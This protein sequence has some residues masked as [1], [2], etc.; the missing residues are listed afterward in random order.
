MVCK[1]SN[2]WFQASHLTTC[3]TQ[4]ILL[5]FA[6]AIF[7]RAVWMTNVSVSANPMLPRVFQL[8]TLSSSTC[9]QT[10]QTMFL[11][12]S[13]FPYLCVFIFYSNVKR[14][15]HYNT[16]Q[17]T[18]SY[19]AGFFYFNA[20]YHADTGFHCLIFCFY[21]S[22]VNSASLFIHYG[23]F[24]KTITVKSAHRTLKHTHSNLKWTYICELKS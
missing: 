18:S 10:L 8:N 2:V 20:S 15:S 21:Q 22:R 1:Y 7:T 13:I 6:A 11:Q 17:L 23:N 9:S 4:P 16:C 19:C 14:N 24:I 3:P 5:Y 12:A